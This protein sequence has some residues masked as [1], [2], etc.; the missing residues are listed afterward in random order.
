MK[1]YMIDTGIDSETGYVVYDPTCKDPNAP[2]QAYAV[3]GGDSTPIAKP[4]WYASLD[5]ALVGYFGN[6]A[7]VLHEIK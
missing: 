2:Y 7:K 3:K 1:K 5:A 6:D 4:H